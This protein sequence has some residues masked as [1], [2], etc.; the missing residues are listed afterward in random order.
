MILI[1]GKMPLKQTIYGGEC[2]LRRFEI[3]PEGGAGSYTRNPL[4]VC[5]GCNF[6][7]NFPKTKEFDLEKICRC[8]VDMTPE[9]YNTLRREYAALG[10]KLSKKGFWEFVSKSRE[11]QTKRE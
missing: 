6:A 7:E 5:R 4:G 8:P 3:D 10:R 9:E 2:P 11:A 1:I